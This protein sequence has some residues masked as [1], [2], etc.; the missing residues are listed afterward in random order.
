MRCISITIVIALFCSHFVAAVPI[1]LGQKV[2]T[3]FAK[4]ITAGKGTV[5]AATAPVKKAVMAGS[6]VVTAG[7][8]PVRKAVI[9]VKGAKVK[10]AGSPRRSRTS[11]LESYRSFISVSCLSSH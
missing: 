11:I 1:S 2:K 9:A 6:I 5:W 10:R 4:T 8:V 3:G 7:T